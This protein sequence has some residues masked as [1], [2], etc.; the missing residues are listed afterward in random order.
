[1]N[2]FTYAL[3]GAKVTAK[4]RERRPVKAGGALAGQSMGKGWII[5]RTVRQQKEG[6]N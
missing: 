6:K 4:V 3:T 1:V 5:A 2:I